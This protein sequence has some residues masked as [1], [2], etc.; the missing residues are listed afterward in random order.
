MAD[1]R[2]ISKEIY[3]SRRYLN[4][5]SLMEFIGEGDEERGD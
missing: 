3:S 5:K 2:C 4:H 1:R